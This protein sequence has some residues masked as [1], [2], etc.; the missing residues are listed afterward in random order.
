[1]NSLQHWRLCTELSIIQAAFLIIGQDPHPDTPPRRDTPEFQATF[2]ALKSAVLNEYLPTV[3]W[4]FTWLVQRQLQKE[5][6]LSPSRSGRGTTFSMDTINS[7]NIM[8]SIDW[9]QTIVRVDDLC[10]W[11]RSRGITTGFFLEQ[12]GLDYLNTNHP[13]YSPRLAAAV[14]A[15]Q[16][17]SDTPGGMTRK[18]P[19]QA[20]LTWLTENRERF[21]NLSNQSIEEAAKVANW[22]QGGA[23]ETPGE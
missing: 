15:W 13:Y 18:T 10:A 20:L 8:E 17:I 3:T 16:A 7:N 11:L 21:Q 9:L 6:M 12:A 19:K 4:K 14:Q 5:R 22:K 2:T 1:M 23:A